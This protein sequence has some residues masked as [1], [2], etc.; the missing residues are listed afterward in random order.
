MKTINEIKQILHHQKPYLYE[1]YGVT[2]VGVFGSYVRHEQTSQSDLDI[3]IEFEDPIKIGLLGLIGMEEY[4]S[5][6]IGVKVDLTIKR[7]LKPR[8]GKN[9]LKEALML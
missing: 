6:L 8:I 1:K 3:L 5:D 2:E 7:D 4:L 9:I